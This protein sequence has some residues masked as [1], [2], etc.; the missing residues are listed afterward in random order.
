MQG[1]SV[2]S[3]SMAFFGKFQRIEA[4][5]KTGKKKVGKSGALDKVG[6]IE[7]ERIKD[8][9]AGFRTALLNKTEKPENVI[10]HFEASIATMISRLVDQRDAL[11]DV[12]IPSLEKEVSDL[13]LANWTLDYSK[14]SVDLTRINIC[15][16][17][18]VPLAI[19]FRTLIATI[20]YDYF[21]ALDTLLKNLL[22]K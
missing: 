21:K 12:L 1:G 19:F 8:D 5:E 9:A 10:R 7:N 4:Q 18:L 20:L 16:S 14:A 22:G 6:T 2:S 3:A 13:Y 17:W 15:V 11:R